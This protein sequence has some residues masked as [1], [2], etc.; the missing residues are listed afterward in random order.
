MENKILPVIEFDEWLRPVASEIEYRN[1][2]YLD[3]L[4]QIE[5]FSGS[6]YDFANAH[7]FYGVHRDDQLEGWWVRDLLPGAKNVSVL[8]DWNDWNREQFPMKKDEWGVWSIFLSDKITAGKLKHESLIKLHVHGADD[9]K[10]DRIPTFITRVV[11]NDET[12][13]FNGQV[14]APEASFDWSEDD[15]MMNSIDTPIIYE[16]HIGMATEEEKVGSYNEFTKE[17]LPYIKELG[18]NTVQLMAIAEHPYYGSFGY[19]VAN[20]YAPSSR[21]G[22][23]EDLKNLIKEAHNLGLGV[24]MDV[25]H[26]H[27]VK[28]TA[29]G[30]NKF[31]GTEF[32]YSPEGEEGN[33]PQ[34]DSKLYNYKEDRV[35]HLLLSN[36]K[37]WLEEFHFDGFRFDGVTSMIYHHHGYTDFGSYQSFFGD[38]VNRPGIT[39]LTLANKLVHEVKPEAITIAEEVSG[40]PAM[41]A[42]IADGGIGFNYRLAM[43]VPDFWIKYI[44][45]TPDEKWSLDEMWNIMSN[46]LPSTKTITYCESHDQALVGDKTIAF[47]LMDKDMYTSMGKDNASLVVDR[48]IALHKMIRLLTISLGGD[49]YMNFMGNEFGHPEWID[50][51]REDNGWSYKH[52]RRQWS[53]SVDGNLKYSYLLE[54]DKEMIKLISDFYVLKAGYGYNLLNDEDNKTMAFEQSGLIF[55]FN[56]HTSNSIMDYLMP[57]PMKGKYKIVLNSDDTKFGGY[58]RVK[59]NTEFFTVDHNGKPHIKI[60]NINRAALVLQFQD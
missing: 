27:Y 54:F 45:D 2:L 4:R 29:E 25:V 9:S 35:Q 28:N 53:L 32:L 40:M 6:L 56:W 22:T 21:F 26:S 19:H 30:F 7:L 15:F 49:A 47:R 8:G 57:V 14:W 24:I 1:N 34:W 51:P 38:G 39:Y 42:T 36:L 60:Y 3:R 16:A 59:D 5:R 55:V 46:R 50:F 20:L 58:G 10:M 11:Q 13:D 37:Y 18:Y 52:A 17:M 23:P 33:H 44:K 12:K 48:G 41:T 43:A 31:D